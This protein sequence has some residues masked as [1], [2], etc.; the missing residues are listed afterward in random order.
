MRKKQDTTKQPAGVSAHAESS[1]DESPNT[2]AT[3]ATHT[4]KK[5][6]AVALLDMIISSSRPPFT[7]SANSSGT[8]GDESP[9]SA[10]EQL[11][12]E[13]SFLNM[14]GSAEVPE[15]PPRTAA[16]SADTE[17]AGD[18]ANTADLVKLFPTEP[19]KDAQLGVPDETLLRID[20]LHRGSGKTVDYPYPKLHNFDWD[21][22]EH[23]NS[24]NAWRRDT[25]VE[26]G[27]FFRNSSWAA[28]EDRYMELQIFMIATMAMGSSIRLPTTSD[29]YEKFNT[30][31]STVH[32]LTCL[33]GSPVRRTLQ[34]FRERREHLH[35]AIKES[36]GDLLIGKSAR[37][38]RR[39][40]IPTITPDMPPLLKQ[41]KADLLDELP[42][43]RK[44]KVHYEL[45]ID[46]MR[47]LKFQAT[48]E[49]DN[50]I[51]DLVSDTWLLFFQKI[52]GSSKE[53][54]EEYNPI[55]VANGDRKAG[56]ALFG[57][58]FINQYWRERHKE[59]ALPNPPI[60]RASD[61]PLAI[62]KAL[63]QDLKIASILGSANSKTETQARSNSKHNRNGVEPAPG[64]L[65]LPTAT[66]ATTE[67]PENGENRSTTSS[68][69]TEPVLGTLTRRGSPEDGHAARNDNSSTASSQTTKPVPTTPTRDGSLKNGHPAH[70]DDGSIASSQAT[71]P[72]LSPESTHPSGW[73]PV[74]HVRHRLFELPNSD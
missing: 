20:Y 11:R 5:A 64:N 45:E 32:R 52:R 30:Y 27:K 73:T 54:R 71:E 41:A 15:S 22:K 72:V 19:W 3:D 24:L 8:K 48:G 37:G 39:I 44:P 23:I 9:D 68:Q 49:G 63:E 12:Q 4:L 36:L 40:Y 35:P 59:R 50:I 1:H 18:P 51:D 33:D 46:L 13:M 53:L 2:E 69:T 6:A 17:T 42:N 62:V 21:S 31:F 26:E 65:R 7:T 38:Y 60:K 70:D 29:L 56:M 67:K 58:Q 34:D 43:I 47:L 61:V 66:L 25:Y 57:L 14:L 10:S 55:T 16:S 28:E 74:N